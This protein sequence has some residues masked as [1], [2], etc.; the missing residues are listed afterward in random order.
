M[1]PRFARLLQPFRRP[2]ASQ[3]HVLIAR[4]NAA[5]AAR[6]WPRAEA[7]YA[8]ALELDPDHHAVWVQYGHS[9]KEQGLLQDAE[10]AYRRACALAPK[11]ADAQVQLGHALKLQGR[12]SEA[13]DA[14]RLAFRLDPRSF[15]SLIELAGQGAVQSPLWPLWFDGGWYLTRYPEA[16]ATRLDPF[17]Y[18]AGHGRADGHVP[19]SVIAAWGVAVHPPLRMSES[20][21]N[22]QIEII[23]ASQL[24]DS[25]WYAG[26]HNVTA[27]GAVRHYVEAGAFVGADPNPFFSSAYYFKQNPDVAAQGLN[28]LVHCI[29]SGFFAGRPFGDGSS[30]RRLTAQVWQRGF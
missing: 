14:Y 13:V 23:A 25:P 18:Y 7:D 27:E 16:A 29:T 9:L 11:D 15:D 19:N 10:R 22:R 21:A 12:R 8:A 3:L 24:L 6:N 30:T 28:P 4:A 2:E 17:E 26:R 1:P 5:N 20:E